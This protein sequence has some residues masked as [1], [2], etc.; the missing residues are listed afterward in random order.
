MNRF[1]RIQNEFGTSALIRTSVLLVGLFGMALFDYFAFSSIRATLIASI[2][3]LLGYLFKRKIGQG[4][5]H[6]PRVLAVGLFVYPIILL[7]G[8]QLGIGNGAK[9]AIITVTTVVIFNLQF[10]SLSDPSIVNAER[11]VQE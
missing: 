10:W 1:W 5:E 11:D 9:L 4:A 8:D 6:Y 7:L 3:L 2:G